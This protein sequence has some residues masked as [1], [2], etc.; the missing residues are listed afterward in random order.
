MG[1]APS[2]HISEGRAVYHGGKEAE[3]APGAAAPL[4]P[5]AGPKTTASPAARGAGLAEP[6]P[7]DGSG[8]KVKGRRAGG[9]GSGACGPRRNS[10]RAGPGGA[11]SRAALPSRPAS[12]GS[13]GAPAPACGDSGPREA[14]AARPPTLVGGAASGTPC[15]PR[16]RFP[17]PSRRGPRRTCPGSLES[18]PSPRAGNPQGPVARPRNGRSA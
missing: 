8:R 5:P 17:G 13:D 12:G 6:E 2:I 4:P 9:R 3:D 10:G 18:F 11:P 7:R 16:R 14:R 15:E 1:C